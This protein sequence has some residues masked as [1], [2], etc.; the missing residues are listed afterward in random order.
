MA[1]Q[2]AAMVRVDSGARK[3][4]ITRC[5]TASGGELTPGAITAGKC[6]QPGSS[7]MHDPDV[8]ARS[9]ACRP[10]AF[11]DGRVHSRTGDETPV[12]PV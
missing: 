9:S 10:Q 4:S 8:M 2:I 7:H 12:R 5:R 6:S 1:V 3:R 11:C